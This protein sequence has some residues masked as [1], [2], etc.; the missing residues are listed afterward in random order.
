MNKAY[1]LL[2]DFIPVPTMLKCRENGDFLIISNHRGEI[3]YL[4]NVAQDIWNLFN[5]DRSIE[6]ILESMLEEYDVERSILEND[7]INFIRDMQWKE[8]VQLR[9]PKQ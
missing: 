4:N 2:R 9:V 5:N 3:Y 1:A 8:V 6:V 7:L